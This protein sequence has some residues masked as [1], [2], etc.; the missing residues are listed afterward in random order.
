MIHVAGEAVAV[1]LARIFVLRKGEAEEEEGEMIVPQ[2]HPSFRCVY[3]GDR[4]K[5]KVCLAGNDL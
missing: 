3:E 5:T 1:D 2:C 4:V